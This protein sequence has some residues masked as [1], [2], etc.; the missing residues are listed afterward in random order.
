MIDIFLVKYPLKPVVI[1]LLAGHLILM[2]VGFLKLG[3][4]PVQV[5][6]AEIQATA[7]TIDLKDRTKLTSLLKYRH[8]LNVG[9]V[10][11]HINHSQV[12]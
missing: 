1:F 12:G 10:G 9:S 7:V 5:R 3:L 6:Y 2:S 4:E 8:R 11:E